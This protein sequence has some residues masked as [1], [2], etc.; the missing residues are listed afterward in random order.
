[1]IRMIIVILLI[2]INFIVS[3]AR[4]RRSIKP[5]YSIAPYVLNEYSGLTVLT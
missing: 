5:V 1:M 4:L 2:K 3:I